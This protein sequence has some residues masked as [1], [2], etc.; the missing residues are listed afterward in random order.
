MLVDAIYIQF[1][2][3]L[4]AFLTIKTTVLSTDAINDLI[5]ASGVKL[6]KKE[7]SVTQLKAPNPKLIAYFKAHVFTKSAFVV[8]TYDALSRHPWIVSSCHWSGLI[9]D[10][11]HEL[12][13]S[14][15]HKTKALFGEGIDRAPLLHGQEYVPVLAMSGTFPK[16]RPGDWFVWTRL[17]AADSGVYS[18]GSVSDA[19]RRFD[20]RFDGLF[21]KEIWLKRGGGPPRK[22]TVPAK[23]PPE[24][25][26]EI[27]A[28]LAPFI[29]RRLKDEVDDLPPMKVHV[30]R[31]KTN[32]L[33]LD[34]IANMRSGRALSDASVALLSHH[35]LLNAKQ[36]FVT[37]S[38]TGGGLPSMKDL[39]LA[40]K[41]S[42]VSSLDKASSVVDTISE[43]GWTKTGTTDAFAVIVFHRSA[44]AEASRQL[45]LA[46]ISHFTMSQDDTIEEREAK[47]TAFQSGERMAF[48]T[49]YGVGGTGLNLTRASRMI[50]IGLP[51]TDTALAQARDRI[52]RIGQTKPTTIVIALLKGSIDES[53]Y[54]LIKHKGRANFKTAA[55]DK[56]RTKGG[57]IPA[58]ATGSV[59][60]HVDRLEENEG[61]APEESTIRRPGSSW[62]S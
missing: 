60:D 7:R 40:G 24:H 47:K 23:G 37:E 45:A 11:A 19:Q 15:T 41:L 29:V 13:G 16:N 52:F 36:E 8:A 62:L 4:E 12:K 30:H 5:E 49:S 9:C 28:I 57:S 42:M 6:T 17:T 25:G 59:L 27:K 35:K 48:L 20:K 22:I 51:W 34:V 56:L 1:A 50:M 54:Y 18:S 2:K 61:E 38:P 21:Y 10:E 32:G 14:S 39:A 55:V 46:G 3:E 31:I 33:Y 26:D 43:L 58:W 44:L 53:T